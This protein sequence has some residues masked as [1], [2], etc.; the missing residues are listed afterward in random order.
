MPS[1]FTSLHPLNTP[2]TP[3]NAVIHLKPYPAAPI[4]T[5]NI[6]INCIPS[7]LANTLDLLYVMYVVCTYVL[8][9]SVA[10]FDNIK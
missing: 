4:C 7:A 5:R 1:M 8:P 9:S 10:R 2:N 6:C 3:N